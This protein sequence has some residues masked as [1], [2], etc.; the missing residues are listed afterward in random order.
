MSGTGVTPDPPLTADDLPEDPIK[1][2]TVVIEE[3]DRSRDALWTTFG[4]LA[5]LLL[6]V[7]LWWVL[8]TWLGWPLVLAILGGSALT[9]IVLE[10][11]NH[12][13]R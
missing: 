4:M 12:R 7:L 5:V 10:W 9:W 2:I 8:S 6:S 11:V 3:R 13:S 1:I